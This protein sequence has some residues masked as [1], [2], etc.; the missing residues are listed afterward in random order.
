MIL[1]KELKQNSVNAVNIK[2]RIIVKRVVL[3]VS[4]NIKATSKLHSLNHTT[5]FL[6]L[7]TADCRLNIEQLQF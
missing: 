6:L 4:R 7:H 2:L 5:L 3:F 1:E